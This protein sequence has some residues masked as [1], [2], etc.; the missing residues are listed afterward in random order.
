M[1]ENSAYVFL[2]GNMDRDEMECR[3]AVG[4]IILKRILSK[5]DEWL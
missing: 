4:R 5:W 1:E 2:V 3:G